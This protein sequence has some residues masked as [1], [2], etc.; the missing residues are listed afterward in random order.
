L[1]GALVTQQCRVEVER[2]TDGIF[3]VLRNEFEDDGQALAWAGRCTHHMDF[4]PALRGGARILFYKGPDVTTEIAEAA[5]ET[6][7]RQLRL[8]VI[9]RYGL[10]DDL[11]ARTVVEMTRVKP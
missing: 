4:A 10:P 9:E 2:E 6:N 3:I 8:R 11:G 7:K 5:P 1:I